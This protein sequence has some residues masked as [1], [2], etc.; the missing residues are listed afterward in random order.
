MKEFIYF[1]F[2]NF[3]TWLGCMS[4]I[5]LI[6]IAII[7]LLNNGMQAMSVWFRG[8]PPSHTDALGNIKYE[9]VEENE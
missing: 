1:M 2:T 4:I 7:T 6:I 8:Y 3:W 5:A 9:S